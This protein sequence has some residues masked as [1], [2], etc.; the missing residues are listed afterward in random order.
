MTGKMFDT[1][2]TNLLLSLTCSQLLDL[3]DKLQLLK[4]F[5]IFARQLHTYLQQTTEH[6][7]QPNPVQN[8]PGVTG[9]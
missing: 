5:E 6:P 8:P 7:G 2:I 4:E 1:E 3:P 9:P